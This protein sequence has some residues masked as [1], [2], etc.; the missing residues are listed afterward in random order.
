MHLSKPCADSFSKGMPWEMVQ[1]ALLKSKHP[2][3]LGGSPGHEKRSD[4]AGRT[5]PK[6]AVWALS[7][8]ILYVLCEFTRVDL[9]LLGPV[10]L[11]CLQF[12]RLSFHPFLWMAITLVN[13]K[14]SGTSLISQD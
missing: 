3:P 4:C 7:L 10:R 5:F 12:S 1:K 2:P 11:T 14:S 9:F 8:V 13:L 6:P